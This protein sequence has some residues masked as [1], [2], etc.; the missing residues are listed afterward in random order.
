MLPTDSLDQRICTQSL[1]QWEADG[2]EE[3][4]AS[5]HLHFI[6]WRRLR[7]HC[8]CNDNYMNSKWKSEMEINCL[9]DDTIH[10]PL[11]NTTYSLVVS[12]C[13]N[14][15]TER[16]TVSANTGMNKTSNHL[17][18]KTTKQSDKHTDTFVIIIIIHCSMFIAQCSWYNTMYSATSHSDFLISIHSTNYNYNYNYNY[19]I[20]RLHA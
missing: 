6:G 3:D 17:N 11:W 2:G 10:N 19:E 7:T 4:T 12:L 1:Q 13:D 15:T 8:R 18:N 16:S 9:L 14:R 20:K 5:M